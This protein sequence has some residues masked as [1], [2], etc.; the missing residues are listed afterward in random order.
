[1]KFFCILSFQHF[2]KNVTKWFFYFFLSWEHD[3]A[4]AFLLMGHTIWTLLI[5]SDLVATLVPDG[6]FQ[7][8]P[9][10]LSNKREKYERPSVR[11]LSDW[12]CSWNGTEPS[13]FFKTKVIKHLLFVVGFAAKFLCLW[14]DD[15]PCVWNILLQQQWSFPSFWY[16]WSVLLLSCSNFYM[17]DVLKLW[18][19]EI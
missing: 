15:L 16:Y 1:M 12:H 13:V 7:P 17:S 11:L 14:V 18:C 10:C 3:S 9:L 6:R 8:V 5:L 19:S 2:L 4:P